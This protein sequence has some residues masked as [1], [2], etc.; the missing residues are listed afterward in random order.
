MTLA[1]YRAEWES[2]TQKDQDSKTAGRWGMASMMT[3]MM[4]NLITITAMDIT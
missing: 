1:F 2:R 4:I 3:M